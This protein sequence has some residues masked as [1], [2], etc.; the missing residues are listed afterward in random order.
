MIGTASVEEVKKLAKK[1]DVTLT[2]YLAALYSYA[3]YID[4]YHPERPIKKPIKWI[5][6]WDQRRK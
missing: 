2:T 3:A 5:L 1:Y 6:R 4:A